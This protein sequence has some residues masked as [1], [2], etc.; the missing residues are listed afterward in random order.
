M[1]VTQADRK[2]HRMA[3]SWRAPARLPF[4][5][6]LLLALIVAMPV[7]AG[8]AEA[9]V[10]SATDFFRRFVDRLQAYDAAVAG[11]YADDAVIAA[12]INLPD[13]TSRAIALKGAQW[14]GILP[15]AMAQARA[16]GGHD[17][18][19]NVTVAVSG[20]IA[21]VKANRY[22]HI[23]CYTDHVYTMRLK[24]QNDGSYRIVGEASESQDHSSC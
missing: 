18:F 12:R 11:L 24:R 5:R 8:A 1:P 19:T 9:D 15:Q 2:G 22:D 20:D 7:P 16:E 17:S 10:Q 4:A 13:G 3:I 14:K 6:L 21:V 23:R